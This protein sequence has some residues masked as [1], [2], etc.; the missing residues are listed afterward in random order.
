[1]RNKKDVSVSEIVGIVVGVIV[2]IL[3][4][5]T[6]EYLIVSGVYALVC[7]A[8]E[9]LE[10]SWFNSLVITVVTMAL[11]AFFKPRANQNK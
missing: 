4:L 7:M 5:F 9:S 11:S 10:F 1:M 8:V 6:I 2:A 3:V